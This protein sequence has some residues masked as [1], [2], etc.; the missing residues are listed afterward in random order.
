MQGQC[1]VCMYGLV[2][3]FSRVWINRVRL[4]ISLGVSW[5]YKFPP[6][7]VRAWEFGLAIKVWPF[8]PASA[9]WLCYAFGCMVAIRGDGSRLAL[10][11]TLSIECPSPILFSGMCFVLLF[12]SFCRFCLV[13]VL[14]CFVFMLSL[15]LC[16]TVDVPLIFFLSSRARTG[17][18]TTY[19]TGYG[20]D[21]IG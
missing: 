3:A 17:L 1:A 15:E 10:Y 14:F 20:W 21:S 13:F 9:C 12:I 2:I 16:T 19:I 18:A 4:P 11:Q 8:R 7:P 5:T 6:V